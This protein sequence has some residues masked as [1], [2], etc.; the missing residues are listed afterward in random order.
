D[1]RS[2]PW[3]KSKDPYQILIA[4]IMLQR[5]KAEQVVPVFLKFIERF[6]SPKELNN[7][8]MSEIESY[9]DKLGLIWRA[10]KVK[11]LSEKL[12]GDY[13]GSVPRERSKLLALPGVGDYVADAVRCFAF[14]EDVAIIDSNV[15]RVLRRVFGLE[16]KSEARRSP[17]YKEIAEQLA[18][19]G[20]CKEYNWAI[21]DHASDIC[22]PKNPKCEI[23]SLNTICNYYNFRF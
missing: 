17:L 6:P 3:R 14:D 15:C 5:T 12:V 1:K 18:P 22:R 10:K 20:K 16:P 7:A 13:N 21:I 4:E 23:C 8:K 11:C 2:F 19:R 9:F